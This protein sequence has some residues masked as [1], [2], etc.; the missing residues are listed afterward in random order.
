M[1]CA[2]IFTIYKESL[3]GSRS[4]INYFCL[5]KDVCKFINLITYVRYGLRKNDKPNFPNIIK[6]EMMQIF[7]K[8]G[9]NE[10]MPRIN[11]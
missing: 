4:P 11:M 8:N 1:F 10:A 7:E 5:N 9:K 2:V 6:R 3:N